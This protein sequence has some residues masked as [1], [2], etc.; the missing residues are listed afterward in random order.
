MVCVSPTHQSDEF[1][2]YS[3]TRPSPNHLS[4]CASCLE[5]RN[6]GGPVHEAMAW[7]AEE[8]LMGTASIES[9]L[10]EAI[11][12]EAEV[13]VVSTGNVE[14]ELF[15]TTS[16]EP[17]T[18]GGQNKAETRWVLEG[19][20]HLRMRMLDPRERST[21]RSFQSTIRGDKTMV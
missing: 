15:A 18:L 8:E 3:A 20:F 9:E 12:L 6:A 10:S 16:C 2:E 21:S 5:M 13:E 19:I 11:T 7:G 17:A 14:I 1:A 4:H